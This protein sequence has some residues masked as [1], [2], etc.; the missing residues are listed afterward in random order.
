MQV[1][2]DDSLLEAGYYASGAGV[3]AALLLWLYFI[4]GLNRRTTGRAALAASSATLAWAML[5]WGIF[6][7]PI[8]PAFLLTAEH[9]AE[10]LTFS[11]WFGLSL[12]IL[13]VGMKEVRGD[14]DSQKRLLLWFVAAIATASMLTALAGFVVQRDV[15]STPEG[16][17]LGTYRAGEIA[18]LLMSIVGLMLME[19]VARN[20]RH[21][22]HWN[23]KYL[24]LGLIILFVYA[25][26]K[27]AD[28]VLFARP[29]PTMEALEGVVLVFA[30]PFLIIASARNSRQPM[31]VNISRRLVLSTSSLLLTGLYLMLISIGGWWLREFGG[32]WGELLAVLF[33][34]AAVIVGLV[35]LLSRDIRERFQLALTQNL[36]ANK[37]DF[38][39]Q[40]PRITATLLDG[41]S[42][43]SLGQRG[44]RA[45]GDLVNAHRGALWQINLAG[46]LTPVACLNNDWQVPISSA[47]ARVLQ[48]SFESNETAWI[49]ADI[50]PEP[51][52]LARALDEL[53]GIEGASIVVPLMLDRSLWGI[54]I[55]SAPET[56]EEIV[57]DDEEILRVAARQVA[58]VMALQEAHHELAQA[59]QLSAFNQMT[60]F[61]VHDLKTIVSQ[62]SLL[63]QNASKHA[64]NPRFVEDMIRTTTHAVE[65]MKWLLQQLREP[66]PD[67]DGATQPTPIG[68]VLQAVVESCASLEPCPELDGDLSI[69]VECDPERVRSAL[70]HLVQNA[71]EACRPGDS[72][73]LTASRD[74]YWLL[75]QVQDTGP[76][77]SAE[78][79]NE[80]L[81]KPFASTKGLAGMGIGSWQAREYIRS[82]GGDIR[83]ESRPGQGSNFIIRL[84]LTVR[85]AGANPPESVT[86]DNPATE[87]GD[88][89]K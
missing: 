77:M 72:V 68:S 56:G 73:R 29:N 15:L 1:A 85:S 54:V 11:L 50:L 71:Q 89:S 18:T 59:N 44:I 8:V 4:V 2:I 17:L 12:R 88:K 70:S 21:T 19:Q 31:N 42:D 58:S 81:F 82:L 14:G 3:F 33:I 55:L 5:K 52:E 65:R 32:N 37:H 57:W 28:V 45:L 27:S 74:D 61:V 41:R 23:L 63:T 64:D 20:T 10:T 49:L 66:R 79:I 78:F 38:R 62:L 86:P 26:L 40:W 25:F 69:V 48:E 36:F 13:D 83:V 46:S 76:G 16:R 60:A 7:R 67:T 35:M 43:A 6:S 39:E 22:R 9:V 75:V 24:V 30:T 80:R 84:P 34:L 47:T 51:P 53:R 87:S